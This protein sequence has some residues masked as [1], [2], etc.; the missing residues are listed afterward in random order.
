MIM[1]YVAWLSARNLKPSPMKPNTGVE[2]MSGRYCFNTLTLT[3]W[4]GKENIK[5]NYYE[6][7][8]DQ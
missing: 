7:D 6:V 5:L 1:S 3:P 4:P 8:E 2:D